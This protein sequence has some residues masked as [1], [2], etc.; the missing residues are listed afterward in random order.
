MDKEASWAAVSRPPALWM[1]QQRQSR[2]SAASLMSRMTRSWYSGYRAQSRRFDR[3]SWSSV[4]RELSGCKVVVAPGVGLKQ[5][6][7]IKQEV[8]SCW[9]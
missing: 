1:E 7:P 2:V 6:Q 3:V 8:G 4:G 9:S 5:V